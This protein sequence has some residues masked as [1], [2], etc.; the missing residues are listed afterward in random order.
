MQSTWLYFNMGWTAVF[1]IFLQSRLY[2]RDAFAP[3]AGGRGT[4]SPQSP[5]CPAQAIQPA[6]ALSLES[7]LRFI[8]LPPWQDE[9]VLSARIKQASILLEPCHLFSQGPK[10]AKKGGVL[11]KLIILL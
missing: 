10:A 4:S 6:L 7:I 9:E 8:D 1:S 3:K 2:C 5:R 11:F